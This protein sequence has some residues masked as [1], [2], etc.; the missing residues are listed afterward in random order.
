MEPLNVTPDPKG[1]AGPR[2]HHRRSSAEPQQPDRHRPRK[3]AAVS[4]C[5]V[6]IMQ[7]SFVLS[8]KN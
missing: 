4:S 7:V 1:L 6:Q 3:G 2:L 5:E 8:K